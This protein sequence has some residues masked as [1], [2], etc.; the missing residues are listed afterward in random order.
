MLAIN[1]VAHLNF[2][3]SIDAVTLTELSVELQGTAMPSEAYV[4]ARG[5][6]WTRQSVSGKRLVFSGLAIP[7]SKSG[8]NMSD[9]F[10]V[11]ANVVPSGQPIAFRITGYKFRAPSGTEVSGVAD[12]QTNTDY[13][14]KA[15]PVVDLLPGQSSILSSGL[16]RMARACV[17]SS[18]DSSIA[19]KRIALRLQKVG[20]FP[21][22]NLRANLPDITTEVVGERVIFTAATERP[23]GCFDVVADLEGPFEVGDALVLSWN[24]SG[25]GYQ[26]P[27]FS[28]GVSA[29][30][31]LVWSDLSAPIHSAE[32]NDWNN[33]YG[34]RQP[35]GSV[36][37]LGG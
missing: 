24:G 21:M 25:S 26:S 23:T 31:N 16:F 4:S 14:Y 27:G 28:G 12:L 6:E 29:Q 15:F 22:N 9:V 18:P 5:R 20:D 17:S 37:V 34:V 33:D 35:R 32:S 3:P 2:I 13:V 8:G 36:S 7:I 11:A 19:W 1:A 10:V 30:S